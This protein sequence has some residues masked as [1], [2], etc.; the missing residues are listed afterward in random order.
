MTDNDIQFSWNA[1]YKA[2][3]RD[4]QLIIANAITSRNRENENAKA[5][6]QALEEVKF[7]IQEMLIIWEADAK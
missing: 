5:Y 2:G 4:C 1:G 3:V 6:R 7:S